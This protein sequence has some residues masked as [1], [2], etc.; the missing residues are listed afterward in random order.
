MN[1]DRAPDTP[2]EA[3]PRR[4]ARLQPVSPTNPCP[5]CRATEGCLFHDEIGVV[6][7][8]REPEG[9][10]ET[11]VKKGLT[12]YMHGLAAARKREAEQRATTARRV[13]AAPPPPAGQGS[14]PQCVTC[15]KPA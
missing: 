5:R 13:T 1:D 8:L 6:A 7:C 9:S 14:R 4:D 3:T 15:G 12:F 11:I 10:D 2:D